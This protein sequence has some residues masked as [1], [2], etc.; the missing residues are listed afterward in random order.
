MFHNK[1]FM[2]VDHVVMDCFEEEQVKRN[3][4]EFKRDYMTMCEQ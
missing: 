2:D 4:D 3:M 1:Y